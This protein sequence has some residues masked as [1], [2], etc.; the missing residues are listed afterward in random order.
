MA[1][2]NLTLTQE[3]ILELLK[4]SKNDAFKVLLQ[5]ALN[6]FIT[7]ESDAKLQAKPHEQ[8]ENR[9]DYRIGDVFLEVSGPSPGVAR[10]GATDFANE[11]YYLAGKLL[12]TSSA[13]GEDGFERSPKNQIHKSNSYG[14][15]HFK[16]FTLEGGLGQE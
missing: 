3:E 11:T 1:Q 2:L 8:T 16:I 9:T 15:L 14:N 6:A 7:E 5:N 13:P 10:R 4:T 12:V